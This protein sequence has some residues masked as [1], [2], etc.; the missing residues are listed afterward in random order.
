LNVLTNG[1]PDFGSVCFG[2]NEE[3][4]R[5]DFLHP[6][7][8]SGKFRFR[9]AIISVFILFSSIPV[10]ST[11]DSL[12]ILLPSDSVFL[13]VDPFGEKLLYHQVER[14][15]SPEAIAN[16]YG[17]SKADFQAFNPILPEGNPEPGTT[18][19]IPVPNRAILRYQIAGQNPYAFVPVFYVVRKGDNLYRIAKTY[20]KMS[21]EEMTSRN[22]LPDEQLSPG[23]LLHVG[24]MSIDGIPSGLREESGPYAAKI[25][26]LR[27]GFEEN[28]TG[29][30]IREQKGVA[31]W[32]P[33]N[34]SETELFALHR[35]APPNSIIE[36]WN[37]WMRERI[38]VRVIGS[39][40]DK[41]HG[42][43]VVVVL[44][45]TAARLLGAVDP[46]FYAEV[47]YLK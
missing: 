11:G 44:S 25:R 35:F 14:G 7:R 29:S 23:Q 39:I 15:Q 30:E 45:P 22:H 31:A 13:T 28:A 9:K 4:V 18:I 37:P 8:C 26:E 24:W 38:Y 36:V 3:I 20:F 16:F 12:Y 10:F 40:P 34:R 42:E 33:H 46:R 19:H 17:L 27:L 43:E 5:Q 21:A 2:A 32:D 1:N 41:M 6:W 47:R